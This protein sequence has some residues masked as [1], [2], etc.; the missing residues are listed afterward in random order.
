MV[1]QHQLHNRNP[2]PVGTTRRLI[3]D[4]SDLSHLGSISSSSHC[5]G[6]GN[7]RMQPIPARLAATIKTKTKTPVRRL[8]GPS[9]LHANTTTRP[10][11]IFAC[12]Q[13]S[14]FVFDSPLAAASGRAYFSTS[15]AAMGAVKIDGTAI[16]KRIREN[17]HADID[18]KKK[19]NPR[20]QP[21]LKIIQGA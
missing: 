12:H 4:I 9:S 1:L 5:G 14:R 3:S 18:E 13:A 7:Q 16:A 19:I 20:Y 10:K 8:A 17:I 15:R 21:S 11:N 6:G 2:G